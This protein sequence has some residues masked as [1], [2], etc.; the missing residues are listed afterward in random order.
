MT[1]PTL[2]TIGLL[3]ALAVALALAAPADAAAPRYIMITGPRLA[4]PI[5]MDDWSE[6]LEF[7]LAIVN[8]PRMQRSGYSGRP[9][10]GIFLFWNGNIWTRPPSSTKQADERA[11]FYPAHGRR[12][13]VINDPQRM[14]R[15]ASRALLVILKRHG[16]P[17]RR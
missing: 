15:R 5:L 11:W 13:A 6:N 8:S 3:S 14:L 17:I 10:Y 12:T 16:V 9:R 2:K 7:E 4:S 1:R